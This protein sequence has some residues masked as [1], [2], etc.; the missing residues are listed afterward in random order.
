MKWNTYL[1]YDDDDDDDDFDDIDDDDD[2]IGYD[3]DDDDD[4]VIAP[5][6]GEDEGEEAK[7]S[8]MRMNIETKP[9]PIAGEERERKEDSV[10]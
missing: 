8:T 1:C 3:D 2:D 7:Q 6:D 5:V 4:D 9:S 10:W